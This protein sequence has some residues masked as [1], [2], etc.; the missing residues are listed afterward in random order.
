MHNTHDGRKNKTPNKNEH[1]EELKLTS[2]DTGMCQREKREKSV[3]LETNLVMYTFEENCVNGK[4]G[5][6]IIW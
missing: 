3:G 5:D 6:A 4:G 1:E 2:F